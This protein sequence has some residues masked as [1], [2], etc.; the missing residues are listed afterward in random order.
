MSSLEKTKKCRPSHVVVDSPKPVGSVPGVIRRKPTAV[1]TTIPEGKRL[2]V[3]KPRPRSTSYLPSA[4][5]KPSGVVQ[6]SQPS[7]PGSLNRKNTK[8]CC[9]LTFQWK[10]PITA[11]VLPPLIAA[12]TCVPLF[13]QKLPKVSLVTASISALPSNICWTY[14]KG[15]NSVII[16]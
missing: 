7:K 5:H 8:V 16:V 14:P 9:I 4:S 3:S 11:K 2:P 6:P 12:F 13:P 1:A 10:K 15:G